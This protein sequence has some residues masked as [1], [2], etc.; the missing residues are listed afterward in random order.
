MENVRNI[1]TDSSSI[2]ILAVGLTV[3]LVVGEFDLSFV[4]SVG[5][6]SVVVAT[7]MVTW[8]QGPAISILIGVLTGMLAGTLA[9]VLVAM[10]RASSFIVTLALGS[11]WTGIALGISQGGNYIQVPNNTFDSLTYHT[12]LGLPVSIFYAAVVVVIIWFM[13]RWTV[14]GRNAQAIG[15]NRIAARLVGLGLATTRI[16]AYTIM[17]ACAGI[18]AVLLTS[19]GGGTSANLSSGLFI[20]PYVAVFFGLSIL[21]TKRFNVFGTVVGALFI[22]TLNTGLDIMGIQTWLGD[23]I[24]GL[25]LVIILFVAPK[26]ASDR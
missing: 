19:S 10:Q 24:L 4:G 7:S 11:I 8:H 5:L 26:S 14:F 12:I 13:L 16:W 25:A 3:V 2:L 9:G 17:G 23:V 1:L 6:V 20:P 22:S 15:S 18:T 21:A